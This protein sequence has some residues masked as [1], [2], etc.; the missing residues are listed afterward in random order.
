[1]IKNLILKK[2]PVPEYKP[3]IDYFQD[4]F[5]EIPIA[6]TVQGYS[7][8]NEADQTKRTISHEYNFFEFRSIIE[9]KN[10]LYNVI[11]QKKLFK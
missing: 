1:M 9:H 2:K 10:D 4:Q 11:L 7:G 3:A 8:I 6:V 5:Q